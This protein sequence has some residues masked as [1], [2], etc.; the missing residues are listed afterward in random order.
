MSIYRLKASFQGLLRP[1]ARRLA[2]AGTTAN[3]VTIAAAIVSL[4]V[5]ALLLMWPKSSLFALVPIWMFLR[6]AFNALDGMLAREHGQESALGAYL[7]EI[8]DVLSDAALLAPFALVAPF[9]TGWIAAVMFCAALTEFAGVL[10]VA[11]GNGRQYD[12]PMG[13]SDRAVV[14]GSLGM[15]ISLAGE[16]PSWTWLLSPVLCVL[17]I[18]TSVNRIRS[19]LRNKA[20]PAVLTAQMKSA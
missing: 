8:A 15:W 11:H 13:K 10:G 14:F 16:L 17:M 18:W 6:M 2:G 19:G 5:G 20:R 3:Q 12:G 7:N 1:T 4:G 9:S